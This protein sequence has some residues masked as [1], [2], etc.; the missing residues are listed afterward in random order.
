MSYDHKKSYNI[1][2]WWQCYL[3]IL[4]HQRRSQIS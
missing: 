2:P 1:G 4:C 3:F